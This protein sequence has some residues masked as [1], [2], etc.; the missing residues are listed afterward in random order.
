[1]S[2]QVTV[3]GIITHLSRKNDEIA[4]L[5]ILPE[6][7]GEAFWVNQGEFKA[8]MP[9][10]IAKEVRI[11]VTYSDYGKKKFLEGVKILDGGRQAY[12]SRVERSTPSPSPPSGTP[13]TSQ[14]VAKQPRTGPDPA[15][16]RLYARAMA[17]DLAQREKQYNLPDEY[18]A[19]DVIKAS[20]PYENHLLSAIAEAFQAMPSKEPASETPQSLM[21]DHVGGSLRESMMHEMLEEAD[22]Q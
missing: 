3:V 20:R 17:L 2:D 14:A 9:E 18:T 12:Q 19:E 22:P 8:V 4:G 15:A 11:E 21:R 5:K 6:P 7:G 16:L 13:R 10:G 1:M